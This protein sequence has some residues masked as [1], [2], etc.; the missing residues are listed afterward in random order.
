MCFLKKYTEFMVWWS[1]LAHRV[2]EGNHIP[3]EGIRGL[4][5]TPGGGKAG[6]GATTTAHALLSMVFVTD[7]VAQN[8]ENK[9]ICPKAQ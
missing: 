9:K 5:K 1:T 3:S 8:M 6:A 7:E 4:K 2:G